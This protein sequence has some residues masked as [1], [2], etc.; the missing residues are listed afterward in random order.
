MR[1]KVR[2]FET[3][4]SSLRIFRHLMV[5][6]NMNFMLSLFIDSITIFSVQEYI[7]KQNK[8]KFLLSYD[9]HSSG[10]SENST[11]ETEELY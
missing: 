1:A 3:L 11:D 6:K 7:S 5:T 9:L 2:D 4:K 8:Q 10:I